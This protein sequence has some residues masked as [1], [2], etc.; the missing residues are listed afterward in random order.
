MT[1]M[2]VPKKYRGVYKKAI[3]GRSRTAAIRAHCL[4]CTAWQSEEVKLCTAPE[5]PLYPY[6]LGDGALPQRLTR[7]DLP[8]SVPV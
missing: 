5:C 1:R 7:A 8:R 2:T 4:M 3:R 6:R